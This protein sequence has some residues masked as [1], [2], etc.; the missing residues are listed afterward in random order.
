MQNLF[1]LS[2]GLES[3]FILLGVLGLMGIIVVAVIIFK[4][5]FKKFDIEKP[6]IS[7]EQAVREELDRVLVP[8]DEDLVEKTKDEPTKKD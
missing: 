4:K 2:E 6:N 3:L 8:V 5:K 1:Y 7:E